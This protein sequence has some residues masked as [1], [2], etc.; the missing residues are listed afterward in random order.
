[1]IK[2]LV[3]LILAVFAASWGADA[4]VFRGDID[5][6]TGGQTRGTVQP[7]DRRTTPIPQNTADWYRFTLRAPHKVNFHLT[8]VGSRPS[9]CLYNESVGNLIPHAVNLRCST[10][11][12][13][14]VGNGLSPDGRF[15]PGTYYVRI[16]ASGG[17]AD[18]LLTYGVESP[19]VH[20]STTRLSLSEGDDGTY[21]VRLGSRP[22]GT[23]RVQLASDRPAVTVSPATL[24]FTTGDWD[25]PQTVTVQAVQDPDADDETATLSHRVTG[26]GSV[27][28]GGAVVVNVNDTDSAGLRFS[29]RRL[30]LD[31]GDT[32]TYTARLGS[33]PSGNVRVQLASD[34]PA[35]TV[36]PATL[37]FTTGDW[38][39]PQT[40]TIRAVP[41]PDADDETAT[42]SH[43]VTGYGSVTDGGAVVV[44]VN[45][46]GTAR[47]ILT[48]RSMRIN[49]GDT[50]TYRARL[51]S[52]PSGN[53]TVQLVSDNPAVT[54]SPQRLTFTTGNWNSWQTVTVRALRDRDA[55]DETATLRH[56]ITGYGNVTDGG[57]KTVYVKDAEAGGLTFSTASIRINEGDTGTYTVKLKTQPTG[58]VTVQLASTN[59]AVT[60]SPQRLTFTS[61]NWDRPQT[62]TVRTVRDA[63][64]DGAQVSLSHRVTGYG[65]VTDGGTV[66][67]G[68][69]DADT[70]GLRFEPTSIRLNEGDTGT[71]TVR[72]ET[73]PSRNVK[74]APVLRGE[75]SESVTITPA[76]LTFTTAN[77][78]R[79]QTFTVRAVPDDTLGDGYETTLFLRHSVDSGDSNYDGDTGGPSVQISYSGLHQGTSVIIQTIKNT[80]R[81]GVKRGILSSPQKVIGRDRIHIPTIHTGVRGFRNGGGATLTVGG[82]PIT[83]S[84]ATL[85]L[86]SSDAGWRSTP[87]A[88][89]EGEYWRYR[90]LGVDEL[91]RSSAFELT[92]GAT[93]DETQNGPL[94]QLTLWGQGDFQ[95]FDS[96]PSTGLRYDGNLKAGYLG[97][98]TRFEKRWLAG[99]AV[100]RTKVVTDYAHP[101]PD[102]GHEDGQLDLTLTT[103]YPY[104]RFVSDPRSE[105]WLL[106]GLGWGEVTNQRV[107]ASARES[108]NAR[109]FMVAGGARRALTTKGGVDVAL[110]GDAG[111]GYLKSNSGP[112]LIDGLS[113]G[114]GQV[115][116][117]VEGSYTAALEAGSNLKP[118]VEVAGRYDRGDDHDVGLEIVG[119]V[120]WTDPALRLGVEARGRVMVL[121]SA[122]SYRE[123]GASVAA[124][125]SPGR[126]GEGLSL[127]LSPRLGAVTDGA[128]ALRRDD[129]FRHATSFGG[130]AVSLNA[131]AGYGIRDWLIRGL[132]TPVGELDLQESGSR[133]VRMGLRFERPASGLGAL[134]LEFSGERRKTGDSAPEHRMDLTGRLRF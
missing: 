128:D 16:R 4:E 78:D 101:Q 107:E 64:A 59:P 81:R 124:K 114:S 74:V 52:R 62:V 115:R 13:V 105:F 44:N 91:L 51:G 106:L 118:F 46:T 109:T 130:N 126:G 3:F 96:K 93:E 38:D 43:R 122:D 119:G 108:S 61:V 88:D 69:I 1:M 23:V 94:S 92:L 9:L 36:S 134:R 10:R 39:R 67:V 40:V 86:A 54:V 12:S 117:G 5:V 37:T 42:L 50:R 111:Y 129:A 66:T 82:R 98:E 8:A 6:I 71:Y 127:S 47:L 95:F 99:A 85:A 77:W 18:Y 57:T 58:N 27:T 125:V 33:R 97:V 26:Y 83:H 120:S 133:R 104:L 63:D 113:I 112:Q 25:R 68:V 45:D 65:S 123:Y 7:W 70:A 34:R 121:H 20:L 110:L 60:V 53:V 14:G 31:E 2:V 76:A 56:W 19:R 35:V 30:D 32:G 21:T 102:G 131:R 80:I 49:E 48:G 17:R 28:D 79:A 29:T 11:S 89:P 75:A 72:L 103:A 55:D 24:T 73:Q 84:A 132:L 87:G 41:D 116:L 100:S 22:A 15:L 90:S